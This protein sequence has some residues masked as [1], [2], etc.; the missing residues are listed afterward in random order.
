L[1]LPDELR[2]KVYEHAVGRNEISV[3]DKHLD[4]WDFAL[5][6]T[7]YRHGASE[8]A[9]GSTLCW[10]SLFNLS[11]TCEQLHKETRYLPWSLNVFRARTGYPFGYFSSL[12]GEKELQ[13]ITTISFSYDGG[14]PGRAFRAVPQLSVLEELTLCSGLTTVICK[15]AKPPACKVQVKEYAEERGLVHFDEADDA[16]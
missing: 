5:Y 1:R 9:V 12:L 15:S 16:P 2:N 3:F 4:V 10:I 7:P 6:A 13:A 8:F 14:V 11:K